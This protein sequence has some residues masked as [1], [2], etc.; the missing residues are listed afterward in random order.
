MDK[1]TFTTADLR[2]AWCHTSQCFAWY[3]VHPIVGKLHMGQTRA[4]ALR[5]LVTI[6][7]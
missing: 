3:V 7:R 6:N 2:Q 4:E 1:P 5:S